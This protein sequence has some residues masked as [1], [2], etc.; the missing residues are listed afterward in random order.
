MIMLERIENYHLPQWRRG[1]RCTNT[2]DS[3]IR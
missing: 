3:A 2:I 1:E